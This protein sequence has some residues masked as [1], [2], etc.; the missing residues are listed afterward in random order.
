MDFQVLGFLDKRREECTMRGL[1]QTPEVTDAL[2]VL[3]G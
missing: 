3:G 1:E 2:G